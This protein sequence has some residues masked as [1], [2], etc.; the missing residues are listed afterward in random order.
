MNKDESIL[1]RRIL[2]GH[3]EDYGYFIER[4]GDRVAALMARLVP[5]HEDAEELVQD[6]FV[7]AFNHLD[8][9]LGNASFVTWIS[10][11]AYRQ[12]VSHLR[13]KHIKYIEID[14]Q[15][16]LTDTDIDEAMADCRRTEQLRRAID[17]LKP[18]EKTLITLYYYDNMPVK[19]MAYIMDMKAAS[20][21][22]R[23]HRIRRKL[24]I[25]MKK[26]NAEP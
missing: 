6:A 2:E 3:D 13:R 11:I 12:A 10:R 17:M 14:E 19:D 1:I 15:T 18:D 8:S 21:A 26:D 20:V 22:T 16:P 5:C 23:L 25:I 4:Y 9:F 7:C 24:Y